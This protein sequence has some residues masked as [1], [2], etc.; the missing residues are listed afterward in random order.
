MFYNVFV[1]NTG[2]DLFNFVSIPAIFCKVTV[3]KL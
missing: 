1:Q 3:R 2:D